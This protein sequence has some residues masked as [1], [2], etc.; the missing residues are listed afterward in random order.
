MLD[1]L[2]KIELLLPTQKNKSQTFPKIL[3][4]H[5]LYTLTEL[6]ACNYL[7]IYLRKEIKI[8][9]SSRTVRSMR[10]MKVIH[11]KARKMPIQITIKFQ[12]ND[13]AQRAIFSLIWVTLLSHL[14]NPFISFG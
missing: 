2:N 8:W 5:S 3:F 4:N 11:L 14:G 12:Y 13:Q 10:R 1:I 9:K 6:A 7:N